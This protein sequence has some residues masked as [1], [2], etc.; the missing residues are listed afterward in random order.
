[1]VGCVDSGQSIVRP[2]ITNLPSVFHSTRVHIYLATSQ[3]NRRSACHARPRVR[4]GTYL[5][6]RKT[7][8]LSRGKLTSRRLRGRAI[9]NIMNVV[10]DD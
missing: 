3:K 8:P 7:Y 10:H 1:M 5:A 2:A 9:E 6:D 4:G